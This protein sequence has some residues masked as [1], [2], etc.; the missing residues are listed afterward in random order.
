MRTLSLFIFC[1][2]SLPAIA[3]VAIDDSRNFSTT[4]TAAIV[5]ITILVCV[6][7][8]LFFILRRKKKP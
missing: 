6:N 1:L 4:D 7:I 3:D 8:I 2:L 5:N